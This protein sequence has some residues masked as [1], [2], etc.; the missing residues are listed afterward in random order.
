MTLLT[1]FS[2]SNYPS[3]LQKSFIL[4]LCILLAVH[5]KRVNVFMK[6]SRLCLKKPRTYSGKSCSD[7][8]QSNESF[9]W[10][11]IQRKYISTYDFN[12][13]VIEKSFELNFFFVMNFRER[14][15]SQVCAKQAEMLSS[16]F[17][18]CLLTKLD[19][20]DAFSISTIFFRKQL[21][22]LLMH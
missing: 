5:L 11:K 7:H 2:Q 17:S 8:V 14:N 3:I 15:K 1:N 19:A 4:L 9:I 20:Y 10:F 12:C 21:S 6:Y 18:L 16:F 22:A 13:V